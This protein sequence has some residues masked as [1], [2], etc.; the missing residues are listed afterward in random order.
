M[1]TQLK[2]LSF[3]SSMEIFTNEG[4]GTL[5]V[6]SIEALTEAEQAIGQTA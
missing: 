5:V 1:E 3:D 6:N 4:T 2:V